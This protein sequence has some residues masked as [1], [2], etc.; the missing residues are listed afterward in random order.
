MAVM[1][2]LAMEMYICNIN[3]PAVAVLGFS[4]VAVPF[5]TY[6]CS[7]NPNS[8][9]RNNESGAGAGTAPHREQERRRHADRDATVRTYKCEPAKCT[10]NLCSAILLRARSNNVQDKIDKKHLSEQSRVCVCSV[11]VCPRDN[12]ST[13][14]RQLSRIQIGLSDSCKQTKS[15]SQP[16]Q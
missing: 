2:S 12:E 15:K 6:V 9:L 13:R 1:C 14:A 7:Q 8:R 4:Q 11:S 10:A 3:I 5:R 16:H